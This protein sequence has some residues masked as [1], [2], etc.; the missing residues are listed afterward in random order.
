[1]PTL[2]ASASNGMILGNDFV[3]PK[4]T[5]KEMKKMSKKDTDSS[6]QRNAAS[7]SVKTS[8]KKLPA[9]WTREKIAK[10]YHKA[11]QWGAKGKFL[12]MWA[13][14][15]DFKLSQQKAREWETK[16]NAFW[17]NKEQNKREQ[18]IILLSLFYCD[19]YS[20]ESLFYAFS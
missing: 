2:K 11:G 3:K 12:N 7:Y 19:V 16:I 9:G 17:I 5:R 15:Y 4:P 20:S 8:F 18:A 14:K 10:A 6:T 1:M 13:N